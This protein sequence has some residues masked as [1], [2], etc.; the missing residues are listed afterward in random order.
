MNTINSTSKTLITPQRK[1]LRATLRAFATAIGALLLTIASSSA[2]YAQQGGGG[3]SAVGAKI[4]ALATNLQSLGRP[5]GL[6]SLTI[7][8]IAF[9]IAPAARQ[10]ASEN[11]SMAGGVIFGLFMLTFITDIVSWV[12]G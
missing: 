9:A 1:R 7:I 3:A 11:K 5:L 8:A 2:A 4:E 6:L 12:M 10:W